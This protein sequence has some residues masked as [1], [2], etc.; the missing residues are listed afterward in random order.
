MLTSLLNRL[1]KKKSKS[2]YGF[3][4]SEMSKEIGKYNHNLDDYEIVPLAKDTEV[5]KYLHR[6]RARKRYNIIKKEL[7]ER[8]AR[9]SS[10]LASH[11]IEVSL[12]GLQS[13]VVKT[14]EYSVEPANLDRRQKQPRPRLR[15]MRFDAVC[16]AHELVVKELVVKKGLWREG[17][18]GDVAS[19]QHYQE[20]QVFPILWSNIDP[21]I[22]AEMREVIGGVSARVFSGKKQ[23]LLSQWLDEINNVPPP[24]DRIE[25]L[26]THWEIEFFK[27]NQR[28]PDFDDLMSIANDLRVHFDDVPPDILE[29]AGKRMN[30]K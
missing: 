12:D 6:R 17:Y 24:V 9:F 15:A 25:E 5:T 23:V 20:L 10:Y 7:P 16:I 26:R 4:L 13:W 21:A 8:A 27:D 18:V 22:N 1:F 14:A 3:R 19:F 29:E 30:R 28:H 2:L 11:D